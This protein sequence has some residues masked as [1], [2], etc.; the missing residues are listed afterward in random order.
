VANHGVVVWLT[1]LSGSGKSTL[2][3]ALQKRLIALG[4][5]APAVLDGDAVR[6]RFCAD[7]GFTP[8]D[9]A[10]NVRRVS[11]VAAGLANAGVITIVALISPYADDR[12]RARAIIGPERFVEV[13]LDVPVEVCERRDPKGLYKKARAGLISDFTGISAPYE[14]P[15]APEISL[16]TSSLSVKS[17]VDRVVAHLENDDF[18]CPSTAK[19]GAVIDFVTTN[20]TREVIR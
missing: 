4:H 3:R 13:Y 5:V 19:P 18:L 8:E 7:L 14:E 11:D 6:Q 1:G 12:A 9:R 15:T 10:E 2:A 16:D 17:C 20:P